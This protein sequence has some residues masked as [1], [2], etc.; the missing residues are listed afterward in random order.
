MVSY[1]NPFTCDRKKSEDFRFSDQIDITDLNK[2]E[3]EPNLVYNHFL[4]LVD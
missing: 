1:E 3:F 2:F 4:R